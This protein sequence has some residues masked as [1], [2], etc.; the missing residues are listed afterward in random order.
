MPD[1]SD[2]DAK[3]RRDEAKGALDL[4]FELLREFEQWVEEAQDSSKKEALDN[5]LTHLRSL[6]IEYKRRLAELKN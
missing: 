1:S 3:R 4:V 2:A 5:V 6:E